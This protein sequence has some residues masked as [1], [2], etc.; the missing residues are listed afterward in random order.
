MP[1]SEHTVVYSFVPQHNY[2]GSGL[3]EN[4]SAA[5]NCSA[6]A[7]GE[8]DY[9]F[10]KIK[11]EQRRANEATR[12]EQGTCTFSFKNSNGSFPVVFY[13]KNSRRTFF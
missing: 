4:A 6:L 7:L 3:S 11:L 9:N 8:R 1:K 5:P 2:I 10:Q 13:N 12:T